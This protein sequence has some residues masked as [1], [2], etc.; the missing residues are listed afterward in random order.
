MKSKLIYK[1]KTIGTPIPFYYNPD[2]K[3]TS[4]SFSPDSIIVNPPDGF[5]VDPP[6]IQQKSISLQR[7]QSKFCRSRILTISQYFDNQENPNE[8]RNHNKFYKSKNSFSSEN[9]LDINNQPN[10]VMRI[11][12]FPS[13][14]FILLDSTEIKNK[15]NEMINISHFSIKNQ[16]NYKIPT[17]DLIVN[18]Q[19]P[20]SITGTILLETPSTYSKIITSLISLCKSYIKQTD[21]TKIIDIILKLNENPIIIPDIILYVVLQTNCISSQQSVKNAW[22]LLIILISSIHIRHSLFIRLIRSYLAIV[23]N[24]YLSLSQSIS[25]YK[26]IQHYAFYCLFRL[27]CFDNHLHSEN[28]PDGI[29]YYLPNLNY[30][31]TAPLLYFSACYSSSFLFGVSLRE[32]LY[33]ERIQMNNTFK[34]KK[35]LVPSIVRKLVSQMI[36]KGAFSTKRLFI[37]KAGSKTEKLNLIQQINNGNMDLESCNIH[38]IASTLMHFLKHL[39]SPLLPNKDVVENISEKI[40]F[41]QSLNLVKYLA[42]ENR[43]TLMYLIGF[44]QQMANY[45]KTTMVSI[46]SIADKF[47]LKVAIPPHENMSADEIKQF[48]NRVSRFLSLLISEWITEDVYPGFED[49]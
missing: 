41:Y 37:H 1:C 40:Q 30:D 48:S 49:D 22:I 19:V 42:N 28:S 11:P 32:V 15:L 16:S 14:L 6:D 12:F 24:Y 23:S 7:T 29:N 36:Q 25:A 47:A 31:K 10:L 2:S 18:P 5:Y 34:K 20:K 45:E 26:E 27:S 9:Y 43:D 13:D 38:T 39:R 44:F 8:S 4:W 35:T 3:T 46:Q 33:K 17:I 21:H